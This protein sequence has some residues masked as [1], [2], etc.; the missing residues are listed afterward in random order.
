MKP[1]FCGGSSSRDGASSGRSPA[2]SDRSAARAARFAERTEANVASASTSVANAVAI[3]ETATQSVSAITGVLSTQR[4]QRRPERLLGVQDGLE[5]VTVLGDTLQCDLHREV[6]R[7]DLLRQ[8]LPAQRRRHGRTRLRPHRVRRRDRLAVPVLAVVDEHAGALLLQPLGRHLARML[9]LEP[10]RESLR[11]LVG[12]LERRAAHDRDDDVDPIRAARLHPRREPELVERLV[13]VVRDAD[14]ER[15]RVVLFGWVEVEQ[16]EIG[17]VGLVDARVPRVHV[18]A[19]HLHHPE[20][21]LAAVDEREVDEARLALVLSLASGPGAELARRDPVRD[22]LR[23]LLL[24][25]RAALETLAP[26]L[27]RERAVL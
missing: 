22:P 11:E 2:S 7:A 8:L 16:D 23:R 15:E 14:A 18:D 20:Q 19:V 6:A 21:R 13:Q 1:T 5:E 10:A 25:E 27:H 4:F 12:V 17:T 9:F 24:E 3:P 26:P